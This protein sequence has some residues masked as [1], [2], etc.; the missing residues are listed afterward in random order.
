MKRVPIKSESGDVI[1]WV[2]LSRSRLE[3]GN[4]IAYG[5]ITD[6]GYR[7]LIRHHSVTGIS[8]GSVTPPEPGSAPSPE[9]GRLGSS[10]RPGAD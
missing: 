5:E 7:H 2:D 9:G 6:E 3:N 1:G 4:L 10:D 8:V